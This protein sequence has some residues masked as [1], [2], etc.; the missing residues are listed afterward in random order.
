MPATELRE[1]Y[2]YFSNEFLKLE[3]FDQYYVNTDQSRGLVPCRRMARKFNENP[4]GSLKF[5]LAGYRGSGKSTELIRLEKEIGDSFFILNFSVL[6]EL[7]PITLDYIELFI[8]AMDK[9]FDFVTRRQI[10][11]S[12]EYLRN[13]HAWLNT[14][15]I[16]EIRDKY[17]GTEFEA[18]AEIDVNLPFLARFFTKL[19]ASLK[20][21]RSLKETLKREIEPKISELIFNCNALITEIKNKLPIEGKKG[22]ILVIEDMDKLSLNKAEDIFYN[23]SSPLT[24][25]HIHTI[26]TYPIALVYHTKFNYV[27]NNFDEYF[28]LP[29]IKVKNRQGAP[30]YPGREVLREILA[31]RIDL[32]LFESPE[33]VEDLIIHSGGCLWDL[34]RMVN[35]ATDH[36]MDFEQEKI[37]KSNIEHAKIRLKADYENTIAEKREGSATITK[38]EKYFDTL[39][40]IANDPLKKPMN[41]PEVLD[42]KQN[43][44]VLG[45]NSENWCDVHPM[46]RLILQERGMLDN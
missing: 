14:K 8:V 10:A 44:A 4:S 15:E 21:S 32:E 37:E 31:K 22:L 34:F 29:M 26:Y 38:V 2:K 13:I 27:K 18:G 41:T 16:E 12:P 28:E 36:A 6:K 5:I 7:D 45:Y 40:S 30:Y 17:M 20:A 3:D 39:K 42:L 35:E 9:L 46:V 24:S 33:L 25:L 11:I 23:H 19:K 43:L 1:V